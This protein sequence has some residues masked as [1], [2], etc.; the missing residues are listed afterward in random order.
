[1]VLNKFAQ[2]YKGT[3]GLGTHCN[4]ETPLFLRLLKVREG[5]KIAASKRKIG[6]LRLQNP[7]ISHAIFHFGWSHFLQVRTWVPYS[8][9]A[10]CWRVWRLGKLCSSNLKIL[11]SSSRQ[12]LFYFY[13]S[14]S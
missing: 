8:T 13:S 10:L 6:F 14:K 3:L 1:V 2:A 12:I 7:A 9:D 5:N 4:E 11:K